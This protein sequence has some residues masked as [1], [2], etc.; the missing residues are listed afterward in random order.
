MRK[1][2]WDKKGE[3]KIINIHLGKIQVYTGS[4]IMNPE[5]CLKVLWSNILGTNFVSVVFNCYERLIVACK[6]N[7]LKVSL[8]RKTCFHG[9][10][11]KCMFSIFSLSNNLVY[12]NIPQYLITK[13]IPE[14]IYCSRYYFNF[15]AIAI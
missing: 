14:T 15:Q 4:L 11:N 10:L 3:K 13:R 7:N 1:E 5:T 8:K 2:Q 6:K 9:M 12:Y